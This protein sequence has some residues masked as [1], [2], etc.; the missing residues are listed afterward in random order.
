MGGA[1]SHPPTCPEGISTR[2]ARLTTMSP[3]ER[4]TTAPISTTRH[5]TGAA[6]T[7]GDRRMNSLSGNTHTNS[8]AVV[9]A[10]GVAFVR[11]LGRRGLRMMDND[12]YS[13]FIRRLSIVDA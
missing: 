4:M 9:R 7:W 2:G 8:A 11:R 6:V 5:T 3:R 13:Y 10:D 1:I 12:R